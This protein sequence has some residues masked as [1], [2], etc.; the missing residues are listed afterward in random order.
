MFSSQVLPLLLAGTLWC[1]G[2]IYIFVPMFWGYTKPKK[3]SQL[4]RIFDET[5]WMM[6]QKSGHHQLRLVVYLP[7]FT[8]FY[9]SDVVIAGFLNHQQYHLSPFR[10]QECS[11]WLFLRFFG[12]ES[13]SI[14]CWDSLEIFDVGSFCKLDVCLVGADLSQWILP[15]NQAIR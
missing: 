7:V 10:I 1:L 4:F 12:G 14:G 8:R 6:V 3:C 15:P 2:L 5:Y 9:T 11:G 13:V